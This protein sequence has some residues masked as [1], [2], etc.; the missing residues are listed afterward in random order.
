MRQQHH[1]STS[2]A[3]PPGYLPVLDGMMG[4]LETRLGLGGFFPASVQLLRVGLGQQYEEHTDCDPYLAIEG[5][6]SSQRFGSATEAVAGHK[7]D[8]AATMLVYLN[9]GAALEGDALA[10]KAPPLAGGE[11]TFPLLNVSI[12]P[13]E[14]LAGPWNNID[15]CGFC[16]ARSMH[17]A[18]PPDARREVHGAEVVSR[19]RHEAAASAEAGQG[20]LQS[21]RLVPRVRSRASWPTRP[22]PAPSTSRSSRGPR[23]A[24]RAGLPGRSLPAAAAAPD[25]RRADVPGPGGGLRRRDRARSQDD[26]FYNK[27]MRNVYNHIKERFL[28]RHRARA[29]WQ[30]SQE[31]G[32][33]S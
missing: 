4:E 16:N 9:G 3:V 11:T 17:A 33:G 19:R 32:N 29:V 20:A 31:G 30:V 28:A 27:I 26:V 8:R 22:S 2:I 1:R 15:A 25:R 14:G 23:R 24:R 21:V 7:T 13:S 10:A 12:A 5:I 18:R 6:G